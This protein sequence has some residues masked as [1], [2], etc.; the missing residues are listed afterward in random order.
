V[1]ANG[2][3]VSKTARGSVRPDDPLGA[4]DHKPSAATPG[5]DGTVAQTSHPVDGGT[6]VFV[7]GQDTEPTDP[8]PV[9]GLPTIPGY[10]VLREFARGGMGKDLAAFDLNLD[11]EVAL[12]ILLP[13]AHADRFVCES[14]ITAQLPH[15]GIPPVY[16]MGTLAGGS[17]FL[18]MKLIA[19]Q[20]LAEEMKTADRPRLFDHTGTGTPL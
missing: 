2:S 7:P 16:A 3:K 9:T 18:A 10:R 8:S 19:G 15:P 12:K 17:P 6:A 5:P 1:P 20:T 14:K 11:R 4:T 13:G